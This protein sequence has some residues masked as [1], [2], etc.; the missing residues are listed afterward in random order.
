ME[1]TWSE[2]DCSVCGEMFLEPV[3]LFCG[4]TFCRHCLVRTMDYTSSCPLCRTV[5]HLDPSTAP[6][7]T[8][9]QALIERVAPEKYN[10]RKSTVEREQAEQK[11]FLPL[12][13]LSS[14]GL[15][16]DIIPMHIFEPRYRLMM[17]RVLQ[18]SRMFGLIGC[19]ADRMPNNYGVV[20]KI[21]RSE[22]LPDGRS[23]IITQVTKRFL[24]EEKWE[25]DGYLMGKVNYYEDDPLSEDEASL[26][27]E[28]YRK[29]EDNHMQLLSRNG[30]Q[31]H[32]VEE[33]MQRKPDISEEQIKPGPAPLLQAYSFWLASTLPQCGE[34]NLQ[35]E[36]LK[37]RNTFARLRTLDRLIGRELRANSTGEVIS[38]LTAASA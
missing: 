2:I 7:C 34:R 17:R 31:A 30:E 22:T 26:C 10:E 32:D 14:S 16:G 27:Q 35:G 20:L 33:L 8:A 23:I 19:G 25:L 29:L 15:P 12:F 5:I 37:G 36:L 6:Q 38:E 4:H 18:G 1:E 9:L 24:V 13:V 11:R 3:S 28:L 21:T